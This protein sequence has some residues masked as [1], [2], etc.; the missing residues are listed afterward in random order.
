MLNFDILDPTTVTKI[1]TEINPNVLLCYDENRVSDD[2]KNEAKD[3]ENGCKDIC[4]MNGK[5][6][7]LSLEKCVSDCNSETVYNN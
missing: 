7:I 6:Y 2:F 1:L 5:K 4:I 3:F